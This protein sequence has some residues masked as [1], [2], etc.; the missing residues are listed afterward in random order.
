[1]VSDEA[2]IQI[3]KYKNHYTTY[4]SSN[5]CLKHER[6]NFS[7]KDKFIKMDHH[8][9]STHTEQVSLPLYKMPCYLTKLHQ[10]YKT[11]ILINKLLSRWCDVYAP[12]ALT[13]KNYYTYKMCKVFTLFNVLWHVMS[14]ADRWLQVDSCKKLSDVNKQIFKVD[15]RWLL[16][17]IRWMEGW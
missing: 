9:H 16:S 17:V 1:M 14:C 8:H 13:R 5:C 6:T 2:F 4:S 11:T 7:F 10:W 15:S 12:W 3:M